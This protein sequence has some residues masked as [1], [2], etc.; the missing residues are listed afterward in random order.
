MRQHLIDILVVAEGDTTTPSLLQDI[1]DWNRQ[2]IIKD[3]IVV[4][5]SES[6]F[7]NV[8]GLL[9]KHGSVSEVVLSHHISLYSDVAEIRIAGV[10]TAGSD[11]EVNS[12]VNAFCTKISNDFRK[13]AGKKTEIREIRIYAPSFL[14]P[15][16]PS[17]FFSLG[18]S[19][20]VIMAEDRTTDT[21]TARA[22]DVGQPEYSK[23]IVM[24]ISSILGLWVGFKTGAIEQ[25][26]IGGGGL[27]VPN[28][29]FF[30][31]FVRLVRSPASPVVDI[32]PSGDPLPAPSDFLPSP[33][34]EWLARNVSKEIFPWEF[35]FQF[36]ETDEHPKIST[37]VA[38][39][40]YVRELGSVLLSL[41][42][43]FSKGLVKDVEETAATAMQALYGTHSWVQIY[44]SPDQKSDDPS[45]L[46]NVD[47]IRE[48]L[49]SRMDRPNVSGLSSSG[50]T[51]KKLVRQ[52][53]SLIDGADDGDA[54]RTKIHGSNCVITDRRFFAEIPPVSIKEFAIG[55]LNQSLQIVSEGEKK[56]EDYGL[57][58]QG[59][60]EEPSPRVEKKVT[61][62]G[63][64]GKMF[65]RQASRAIE[66]V[67]GCVERIANDRFRQAD[68]SEEVARG[69]KIALFAAV[70]AL[71]ISVCVFTSLHHLFTFTTISSLARA[72][73]WVLLTL[74][75]VYASAL[76]LSPRKAKAAQSYL[77]ILSTIYAFSLGFCLLYF[78]PIYRGVRRFLNWSG[79]TPIVLL[80]ALVVVGILVTFKRRKLDEDKKRIRQFL[81]Q[82]FIYLYVMIGTVVGLSR[83]DWFLQQI[84]R[85]S[86]Q[87]IYFLIIFVS[88]ATVFSSLFVIAV[89]RVRERNLYNVWL[90][91][92]TWDLK[93]AEYAAVQSKVLASRVTQWQGTAVALQWLVWNPLGKDG[94][95]LELRSH[96]KADIQLNKFQIV[97]VVLNEKGSK[98]FVARARRL[99]ASRGWLIGQYE[100]LVREFS[101][102][103]AVEIGLIDGDLD[104]LR[105]E[106]DFAPE[107]LENIV[108]ETYIARRWKFADLLCNGDL[109]SSLSDRSLFE[110]LKRTHIDIF[111]D[112][113]Y[114]DLVGVGGSAHAFQANSVVEFLKD[115]KVE[116]Q[117]LLPPSIVSLSPVVFAGPGALV[118]SKVFWPVSI[119]NVDFEVHESIAEVNNSHMTVIAARFDVSEAV[120][121]SKLDGYVSQANTE[122]Y[123]DF[124]EDGL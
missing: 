48:N 71:G 11:G 78:D 9:F 56:S 76:N 92:L 101:A 124:S 58:G 30:R 82:S 70:T 10:A 31:S 13:M 96:N 35:E 2:G 19:N 97:D 98:F 123:E 88:I 46:F 22:L 34:P 26:Q 90:R 84:A 103:H 23:H 8:R 75:V 116:G 53:L 49:I 94:N 87:K 115:V 42:R 104:P 36:P 111:E 68:V 32:L 54:V 44:T 112:A 55:E 113:K 121:L 67:D 118:E 51:W 73:L 108:S 3:L 117:S 85:E 91:R 16:M 59:D 81:I 39:Q 119:F 109:S 60:I 86:R 18:S 74:T 27:G 20:F 37:R 62:L 65:E 95:S 28:V 24:E 110:G 80:T 61:V 12:S 5:T 1:E 100:R 25:N 7:S 4:H 14:L 38:I 64:V 69:V 83:P 45:E 43:L 63:E 77:V 29:R 15:N 17:N 72:R 66:V 50:L 93:L 52:L 41:P 107:T 47:E 99:F 57:Q 106:T 120:D 105:P 102:R 33:D 79:D 40:N 89:I 21:A 6:D 122:T 114:Y